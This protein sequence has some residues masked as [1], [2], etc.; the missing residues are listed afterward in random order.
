M[1]PPNSED[2]PLDVQALAWP[3]A[4]L[5]PIARM[6]ALAAA[7]P[8]VATDETVFDVDFDRFWGFIA[9]LDRSAPA[10]EATVARARI[11]SRASDAERALPPAQ[12]SERLVLEARSPLAGPWI[13]FD[14]VLRPGWCLMHSR[15]G[16]VGM[17]A[18]P[19][20]AERTRFFHFEGSALLGRLVRPLFAWNIRQD[21]RKLGARFANEAS[22]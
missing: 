10:F 12:R 9:E 16:E 21:F 7:M 15:F 22:R 2:A 13:R 5:D 4:E 18:A 3:T 8:H 19:E 11:V 17:A 6:R 14:V 1:T 20:S